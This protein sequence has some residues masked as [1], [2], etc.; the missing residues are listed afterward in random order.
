MA[1]NGTPT[2]KSTVTSGKGRTLRQVVREQ[3]R[4]YVWL[5]RQSGYSL[6]QVN[7]VARGDHP[8]SAAFHLSMERILGERYLWPRGLRRPDGAVA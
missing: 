4:S 1:R 7:R 8:G 6:T 3:G 2:D 5:A